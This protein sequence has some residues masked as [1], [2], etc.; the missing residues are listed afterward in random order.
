MLSIKLYQTMR[1]HIIS[2][3]ALNFC[4][5]KRPTPFQSRSRST[6]NTTWPYPSSATTAPT[7]SIF[8]YHPCSSSRI[9]TSHG[10]RTRS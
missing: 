8:P 5:R 2:N 4:G 1:G 10:H 6:N 7:S 3:L 9:P